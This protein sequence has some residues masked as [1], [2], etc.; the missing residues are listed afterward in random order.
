MY[1]VESCCFSLWS[2]ECCL[3]CEHG[4]F[5]FFTIV[6]WTCLL[7]F[8]FFAL[9]CSLVGVKRLVQKSNFAVRVTVASRFS[10]L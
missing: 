9:V 8:V 5:S 1:F 4:V 3:G 10:K 7:Y 2:S 6:V